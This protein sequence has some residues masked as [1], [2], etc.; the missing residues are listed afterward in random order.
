M[1]TLPPVKAR[2]EDHSIDFRVVAA[3]LVALVV[4]FAIWAL[5]IVLVRSIVSGWF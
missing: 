1:F 2:A 3:F 5:V 4:N